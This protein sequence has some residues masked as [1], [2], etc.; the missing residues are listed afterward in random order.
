MSLP[1]AWLAMRYV[2]YSL[3]ELQRWICLALLCCPKA[4]ATENSPALLLLKSVL[5][6]TWVVQLCPNEVLYIHGE[7]ENAAKLSK[8]KELHKIVEEQAAALPA[9]AVSFHYQ[10]RVC[11][12]HYLQQTIN[13]IN[14]QPGILGP[15]LP[16]ILLTLSLAK[17]E[18]FWFLIHMKRPLKNMRYKEGDW[19]D[20]LFASFLF[21]T[22]KLIGM[23]VEHEM[24]VRRYYLE[25]LINFDGPKLTSLVEKFGNI[26]SVEL[27][28]LNAFCR[29]LSQLSDCGP[30][31]QL[32]YEGWQLDHLRFQGLPITFF[33]Y[34][35]SLTEPIRSFWRNPLAQP[36][37]LKIK[38]Y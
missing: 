19:T 12:G 27:R 17:N 8:E 4:L 36:K 10:R 7:F 1:D 33:C 14:D 34:I 26:S 23:L 2:T 29:R 37:L 15:K 28:L 3:C 13:I 5:K 22:E 30:T 24:I 32:G 6:D 21:F 11:V 9:Q 20:P 16:T 18:I 25:F 35:I 38:N 31:K